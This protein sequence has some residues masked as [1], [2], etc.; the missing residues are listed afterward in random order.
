MRA[1]A[2]AIG[3][4]AE[5]HFDVDVCDVVAAIRRIRPRRLAVLPGGGTSLSARVS[6][7]YGTGVAQRLTIVVERVPGG[8]RV[9]VGAKEPI[10]TR[11]RGLATSAYLRVLAAELTPLPPGEGESAG[12]IT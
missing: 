2:G 4:V 3:S 12:S 1:Q 5:G 9:R 11:M 6:S 7:A 10:D 8:S